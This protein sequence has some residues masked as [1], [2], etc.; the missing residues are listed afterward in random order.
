MPFGEVEGKRRG[1]QSCWRPCGAE[2]I[3]SCTNASQADTNDGG[4]KVEDEEVVAAGATRSDSVSTE[5]QSWANMCAIATVAPEAEAIRDIGTRALDWRLTFL[6]YFLKVGGFLGETISSAT[7][8]VPRVPVHGIVV[9][10]DQGG[11]QRCTGARHGRRRC[12]CLISPIEGANSTSL[13]L[14]AS[15]EGT[16]S[17]LTP[18]PSSFRRSRP[19]R[20][21]TSPHGWRLS[22][23]TSRRRGRGGPRA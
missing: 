10:V 12:H 18:L 23:P 8:R 17:H 3:C 20:R 19:P 22:S 16:F 21:H 2:E 13:E 14:R 7:L 9:W 15:A 11:K 4:V 5:N 1:T 6:T